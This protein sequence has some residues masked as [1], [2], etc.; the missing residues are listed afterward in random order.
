MWPFTLLV[1][2]TKFKPYNVEMK[3]NVKKLKNWTGN[4][5]FYIFQ[6]FSSRK[7]TFTQQWTH[8]YTLGHSE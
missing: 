4:V 5:C 8:C 3:V 2:Q 7:H 1:N 6:N